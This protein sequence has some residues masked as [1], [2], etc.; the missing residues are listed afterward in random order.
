MIEKLNPNEFVLFRHGADTK[1]SGQQEREKEWTGGTE[2][3]SLAE[4]NGVA[5]LIVETDVP[6]EQ[7]ETFNF[8]FPRAP[9]RL[10]L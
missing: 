3:Y 9:K 5:T 6:K 7:E 10:T 1:E 8:R 2:S 4:K